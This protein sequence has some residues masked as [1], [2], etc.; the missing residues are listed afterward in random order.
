MG[1]EEFGLGHRGSPRE[2]K[3]EFQQQSKGRHY[4]MS[5]GVLIYL[6]LTA[7]VQA[8]ILLRGEEVGLALMVLVGNISEKE[9]FENVL[10]VVG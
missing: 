5:G 1:G 4:S 2:L 9:Q 3:V 10:G 8:P 7:V 6:G